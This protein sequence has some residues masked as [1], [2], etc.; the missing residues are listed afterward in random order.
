[1][2][3]NPDFIVDILLPKLLRMTIIGFIIASVV[4]GVVGLTARP[5]KLPQNGDRNGAIL[6]SIYGAFI[7]TMLIGLLPIEAFAVNLQGIAWGGLLLLFFFAALLLIGPIVGSILG[8]KNRQILQSGMKI[9]A[10]GILLT[11]LLVILTI[12][13][14]LVPTQLV[15]GK[16][17]PNADDPLPIIARISGYESSTSDLALSGDGQQLAVATVNRGTQIWDL[18]QLKLR[19]AFKPIPE[20]QE[21][22]KDVIYNVGFSDDNQQLVT[23]A[24]T[25]VQI[26]EIATGK[27]LHRLAGAELGLVAANQKLVTLTLS[28]PRGLKIW[29]MQSGKLLQTIPGEFKEYTYGELERS[30]AVSAD[31]RFLAFPPK[32]F[33]EF[34]KQENNGVIQIWD[35]QSGKQITQL[36]G[37]RTREIQTL[38]FSPDA[39]QLIVAAGDQ[40]QIWNWQ[41]AK[42]VKTIENA[43]KIENMIWTKQGLLTRVST[44]P[45][46]DEQQ[47]ALWDLATGKSIPS[48]FK[49]KDWAGRPSLSG[50]G[51]F[52]ATFTSDGIVVWQLPLLK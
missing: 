46:I 44:I 40:L 27:I 51:K 50:N 11:Y 6:A 14:F 20:N 31:R 1:M 13:L 3:F 9:K 12:Y 30:F 5:K 29:E 2:Y 38:I 52:L 21:N 34:G 41:Q 17:N 24:A 33:R 39:Q 7:G 22:G 32:A 36:I 37:D 10:L 18:T 28:S 8:L 42:Q 19:Q 25:E 43:G 35:L 26:R 4:G 49:D 47:V 45:A 15:I 23:A 16:P 48:F